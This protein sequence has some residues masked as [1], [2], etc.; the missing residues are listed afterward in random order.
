MID[1]AT[2]YGLCGAV[3]IG[4]GT[5][6]FVL[7]ANILRRLLAFNVMG[8]GVFLVLGAAASRS[9]E[10]RPGS[11]ADPVAQALIITGIIVALAATGLGLALLV[12]HARATGQSRLPEDDAANQGESQTVKDRDGKDQDDALT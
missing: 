4:V 2:L 8:S 7:H 3:I 12:A 6:G 5:Y 11:G 10:F 1:T 9:S